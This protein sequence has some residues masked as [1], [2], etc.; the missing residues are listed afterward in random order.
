MFLL[1]VIGSLSVHGKVERA[2]WPALHN[3]AVGTLSKR[4]LGATVMM[5]V[6]AKRLLDILIISDTRRVACH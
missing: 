5:R 4:R 1:M 6:P 2:K 3:S